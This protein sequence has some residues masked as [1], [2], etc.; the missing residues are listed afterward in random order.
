MG[1]S[2]F[3]SGAFQPSVLLSVVHSYG[4]NTREFGMLIMRLKYTD[5]WQ[6]RSWQLARE[7]KA[8][9]TDEREESIIPSESSST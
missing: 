1:L 3:S 6:R 4:G 2:L 5:V 9:K 8:C 7:M